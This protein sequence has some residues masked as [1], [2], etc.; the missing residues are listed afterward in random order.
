MLDF[1]APRDFIWVPPL[2][3]F[4]QNPSFKGVTPLKSGALDF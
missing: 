1:T 4:V 2:P 3:L